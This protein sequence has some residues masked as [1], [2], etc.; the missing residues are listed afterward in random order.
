MTFSSMFGDSTRVKER[1]DLT[2]RNALTLSLTSILRYK[3]IGED[4]SPLFWDTYSGLIDIQDDTF[5]PDTVLKWC[6]YLIQDNRATLYS[7]SGINHRLGNNRVLYTPIYNKLCDLILNKKVYTI[8]TKNTGAV[9]PFKF[10]KK[11]GNNEPFYSGC[12]LKIY[13]Q[14]F[15]LPSNVPLLGDRYDKLEERVYK[16]MYNK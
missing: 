13:I 4:D 9:K 12:E 14:K 8:T 2:L 15:F 3:C 1:F 5:L 7:K 11:Y 16:D 10:K 6:N